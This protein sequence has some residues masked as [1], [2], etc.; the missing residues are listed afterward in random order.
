MMR[1][2][3]Q[4]VVN[5]FLRVL[6]RNQE[7]LSKSQIQVSS[8]KQ[9]TRPSEN[10]INNALSMAH[11]TQ[12]LEGTQY[13]KN[14]S[15]VTEWLDNTDGMLTDLEATLQRVR[16]LAVQG[17]ND[18]LVQVDRDAIAGEIDQLMQHIVD[19]GNTDIGGEYLFAGHDVTTKPFSTRTGSN[20]S[21]NP[22]V[23]TYSDGT[24]RPKVN[25]QNLLDV[26]YNGD[27]K[28]LLTEI[29]KGVT[30]S[31]NITGGELFYRGGVHTPQ[32][33]FGYELPPLNDNLPLE[34]LNGG[35]GV[36]QG[37]FILTDSNGIDHRIDLTYARRLDD[38]LYQIGATGCFEAG[39]EEVPADTAVDLGIYKNAGT[40]K[41]IVG[42]SDQAMDG[43]NVALANLNGGNGVE[44]GFLSVNTSDG[45]TH[46]IDIS[47]AI[48]VQDVID[49]V[50][51]VDG[52]AALEGKYDQIHRRLEITDKTGGTGIFAIESK[53]NQ[54]YIR[55]LPSHTA[56]D[57]GLLQDGFPG[58]TIIST[59]DTAMES[60]TTPLSALNGGK[61]IEL[62]YLRI[63]GR[64]GVSAIVDLTDAFDVQ[65]VIDAIN[66]DTAGRQTAAFDTVTKR[67]VLTDTSVPLPGDPVH[68][69]VQEVNSLKDT[70]GLWQD[71]GTANTINGY[72]DPLMTALN[73]PLAALNGGTG[74]RLGSIDI[75][76]RDTVTRRI[77]LSAAFDVSDVINAINIGTGGA[78]TAVFDAPNHRI[79][80]TDNTLPSTPALPKERFSIAG[81][82]EGEPVI[83][84]EVT[85][86]ARNL[87]LLGK[88][89]GSSLVGESL[90][91]PLMTTASL[92]SS[93]IPPPEPGFI[94]L[95]GADG[96]PHK[97]DLTGATTIQDVLDGINA[98]G[99][100]QATW[101]NVNNRFVVKSTANAPG[102]QIEEEFNTARDL[103]LLIGTHNY[104]SDVLTS[105]PIYMKALPTLIGSLDLD[106]ALQGDTELNAL[107]CT[108]PFNQGVNLGFI[109]V[110]DKAG[111]FCSIDLRGCRTI[112]DVL[113]RLNHP[114]NGV[115][116][117]A[118][119]NSARNGIDI[120]DQNR[121]AKGR[122]EIIDV[123]ATAAADL[124]IAGWT[125]DTTLSG[126]DVDPG[127]RDSTRIDSLRVNEGGVPMG[128]I[129]VQSGDYS[130]E[131]D[132]TGVE[133][134]GELIARLS[135]NT[136]QFNI[137]AWIN[138]DGKR[139][140]L[141]NTRDQPYIKITDL[142]E[143]EP[144]TASALGLAGAR[145]IFATLSDLRDNLLRNDAKAISEKS[146]ASI[147]KDIE[148]VLK[149]HAQVGVKTNRAAAAQTKQENINLHLN[150]LLD[151]VEN[152]D[153]TEAITRMTELTTA[154]QAALQSGAKI[155]QTT[156]MDFLR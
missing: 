147:Q 85:T 70:L 27:D 88:T 68:F 133:T 151:V 93:L 63:T 119:I 113:A 31:K 105:A 87:G 15:R 19:I 46:R 153:M 66:T 41:V 102:L 122:L 28:K 150:K 81:V 32:P 123:D 44:L 52:G 127:L 90:Q 3:N 106:P 131:L 104:A 95:R 50:N 13:S 72:S 108:R 124:G 148:R 21:I 55:D 11:R 110:T 8:G 132:L 111:H 115:Y 9:I 94:V 29:E 65:D 33:S 26:V 78:Q 71:V 84:R 25:F 75:T 156:L 48:T 54:I 143:G 137:A 128:K 20:S 155:L 145:G 1:I 98:M 142:E 58:D 121:G 97:L 17:A 114:D 86:V 109:R 7:E 130:G 61:G 96:E 12:I 64:D 152:V 116:I 83:A 39:I 125:L 112:D 67:I 146:I 80:V 144:S 129:F 101:D 118:R 37:L 49:L 79:V 139:L 77:D 138:T 141:T 22:N 14:I 30:L 107:N 4:W 60:V 34:M 35:K 103:G 57:L 69:Q 53:K 149:F 136:E 56:N 154:F 76:G 74:I 23:V 47:G 140:N 2:S 18:T 59:L 24:T 16:E 91:P 10:P 99:D 51:Q 40:T 82:A 100:F 126:K 92:L 38:V 42:L 117:E 5:S 135:T 6:N 73:T 36:Q 62:G 45:R 89:Q 43:A 120:I 134:I